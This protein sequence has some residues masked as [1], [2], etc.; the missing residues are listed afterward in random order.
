MRI[1]DA[2]L[3]EIK[4]DVIAMMQLSLIQLTDSKSILM[5]IDE[6][7]IR[8]IIKREKKVDKFDTKINRDCERFLAVCTPV[9]DDLRT[10][11]TI[12]NILPSVE[13][14]SDVS[15][16]IAKFCKKFPEPLDKEILTKLE[17]EDLLT[18]ISTCT[19]R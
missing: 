7:K 16:K 8:D 10:I 3:N 13:R 19:H 15:E 1:L 4:L 9:A 14:I 5:E 12:N 2:K 11:M 17:L 6:Q 18:S